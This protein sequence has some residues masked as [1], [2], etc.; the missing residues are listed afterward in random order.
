MWAFAPAVERTV[1]PLKPN[2]LL[3]QLLDR[4]AHLPPR[5]IISW[6]EGISADPNSLRDRQTLAQCLTVSAFEMSVVGSASGK[7]TSALF[8]PSMTTASL[9]WNQT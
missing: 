9:T 2:H 7:P 4:P 1:N 5:A 8:E 3:F 6:I